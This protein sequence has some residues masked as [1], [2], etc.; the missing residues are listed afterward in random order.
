L[1]KKTKKKKK[2]KEK[3]K[4]RKPVHIVCLTEDIL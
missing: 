1:F 4:K 3:R 2:K